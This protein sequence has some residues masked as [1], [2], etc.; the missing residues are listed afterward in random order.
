MISFFFSSLADSALLLPASCL[1]LASLAALRQ[2]RL[3]G[4]L[5]VGLVCVAV[6]TIGAKLAFRA[7]GASI[8]SDVVSPSGHTSFAIVFY[9]AGIM[10]FGAGRPAWIQ[11]GLG[12]GFALFILAVGISRVRTEAHS[13]TEVLIG[14]VLGALALGVSLALYRRTD[15]PTLPWFPVAAVF[16]VAVMAF[17]GRHFSLEHRIASA[18]RRLSGA[19]DVCGPQERSGTSWLDTTSQ[20]P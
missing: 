4:V 14:A 7:C 13:P 19:L 8:D 11:R 18:A 15:R 5:T 9:G 1:F 20:N 16:L 2:W 17:G 12:V 6:L 10:M 3:A